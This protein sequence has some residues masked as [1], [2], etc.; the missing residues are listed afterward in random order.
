MKLSLHEYRYRDQC[1]LLVGTLAK[2]RAAR[3]YARVSFVRFCILKTLLSIR[4]SHACKLANKDMFHAM[5]LK[6]N[7]AAV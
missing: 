5:L 4:C 7:I 2:P 1:L 3:T 6:S